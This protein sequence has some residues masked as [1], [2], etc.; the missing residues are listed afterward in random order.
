MPKQPSYFMRITPQ[1][2]LWIDTRLRMLGFKTLRGY[3]RSDHW[4]R[5]RAG[6]RKTACQ[7]CGYNK[8]Q[9][10]Q[11]HHLTYKRLGR[12]MPEDVVTL[13]AYCH[14]EAH[15]LDRRRGTPPARVPKHVVKKIKAGRARKK[16]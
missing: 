3:Y 4:R 14:R 1:E 8:Q 12:E 15:G 16:R 6:L 2:R 11:V 10:L 7:K 13:C 5:R 9:H